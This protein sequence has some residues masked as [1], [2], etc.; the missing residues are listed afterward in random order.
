[1]LSAVKLSLELAVNNLL[2]HKERTILTISSVSL[3]VIITL[4]LVSLSDRFIQLSRS[5]FQHRSVDIYCFPYQVPVELGPVTITSVSSELSPELIREIEEDAYLSKY[6][7]HVL[8][9]NRYMISFGGYNFLVY[10]MDLRKMSI[11]YP[12]V[13]RDSSLAVTLSNLSDEELSSTLLAGHRIASLL[14]LREEDSVSIF[15]KV[16]TLKAILPYI[17]GYEDYSFI[18]D[19]SVTKVFR[20]GGEGYQQLWI[21]FE[22]RP[23]NIS[24]VIGY[25]SNSFPNL[26]FVRADE[27]EASRLNTL[28]LLRMLQF[29]IALIGIMIAFTATTNTMLISTYERLREFGILLAIGTPRFMVFLTIMWEGLIVSI[30]G[31]VIGAFFGVLGTYLFGSSLESVLRFAFP[32]TGLSFYSFLDLLGLIL[33]LGISS[34]LLPA[35]IAARV[36][37]IRALRWE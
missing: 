31:G 24:E 30:V 35:Y 1:M 10:S 23:D 21:A 3:A 4:L 37:I 19:S 11:F 2:T 34:S 5:T 20:T 28:K 26:R 13:A 16:L 22:Y 25:L 15:G 8:G 27:L 12:S 14:K 17:G 9:V 36:D 18:V 7:P 6:A 33:L 32:L 29:S